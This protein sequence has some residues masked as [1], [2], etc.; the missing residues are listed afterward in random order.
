MS[1]QKIKGPGVAGE[2]NTRVCERFKARLGA[3]LEDRGVLRILGTALPRSE[4][5]RQGG[6]ESEH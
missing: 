3:K 4:R 1:V 6:P 2:G 5:G